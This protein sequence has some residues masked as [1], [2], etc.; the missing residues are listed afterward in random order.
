MTSSSAPVFLLT[1]T[2]FKEVFGFTCFASID[3][4]Y[5]A[6]PLA[7]FTSSLTLTSSVPAA[8]FNCFTTSAEIVP[9]SDA[10]VAVAAVTFPSLSFVTLTEAS[11]LLSPAFISTLEVSIVDPSGFV[12]VVTSLLLSAPSF[13]LSVELLPELPPDVDGV[14][15]DEPPEVFPVSSTVP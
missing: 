8:S 1:A 11:V 3:T 7:S 6:L 10:T 4:V 15:E 14:P 13:G 2:T 9:L 5:F 12:S